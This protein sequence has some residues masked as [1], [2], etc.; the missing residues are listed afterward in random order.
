MHRPNR[1]ESGVIDH[2]GQ[3][4]VVPVRGVLD[5]VRV[6]DVLLQGDARFG[7]GVGVDDNP[8]EGEPLGHDLG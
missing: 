3:L 7:E 6:V 8:L 5:V 1:F 4:G 2:L